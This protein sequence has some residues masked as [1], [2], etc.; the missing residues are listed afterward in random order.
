MPSS[1]MT[2]RVAA[3][4]L[5]SRIDS[6]YYAPEHL[7][8]ERRLRQLGVARPMIGEMSALVTDGTHKTPTYV[9][10]G[11]PF[12]SATN[13][14]GGSVHF[15]DHKWISRPEFLQLK[16][17]NCAPIPDDVLVAKSGS[18][19]NAAVVMPNSPEFAVFESIAIVRCGRVDASYLATFLNSHVG[20]Q[21]I[22]RQTKGAVIRHLHLE[23]LRAVEVPE[24]NADAQRYIG[25]KVRQAEQLRARARRLEMETLDFFQLAEWTEPR[26]GHRRSYV[27][28]RTAMRSDRLDAAFY[29]PG[30]DDLEAALRRRGAIE[31]GDVASLVESRWDRLGA[32]FFYFEIGELDVASGVLSPNRTPVADAPSRAQVL[33]EPWDVL[34]STVRPN[35]KNV[36]VVLPA[37]DSLPLVASSGFSALRFRTAA[38]AAF[39]HA[40]LRSDAATQQLMRWNSGATYPAIEGDIPLRVLAP[41]YDDQV[42]EERGERWL[43]KFSAL[44]AATRLTAAAKRIV[45]ALIEGKV[46]ES[47]LVAAQ[48]ALESGDRSVDRGLMQSLRRSDATNEPALFPDLDAVYALFDDEAKAG[49]GD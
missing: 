32:E 11:V 40:F 15:G 28:G 17:W 19:G 41:S 22:R 33:V 43:T 39:H 44:D 5:R 46:T 48:K 13:I 49:G 21:E 7:A 16:A 24:F 2:T 30:H 36:G 38:S 10:E 42:V 34:V 3:G 23:D 26:A 45:E 47:D 8:R 25:N 4:D 9:D 31:I 1:V 6:A 18:I 37:D 14:D 12:L 35:R 20:Q 29:D 27:A